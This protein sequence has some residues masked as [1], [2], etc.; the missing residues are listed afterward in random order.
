MSYRQIIQ[1]SVVVAI[2]LT[3]HGLAGRAAGEEFSA[4]GIEFFE[5]RVRPVFV[6]RCH[7]CHSAEAEKLKGEFRVD[8]REALLKG[9]ES[10]QPAILPGDAD[11]SRLIEAVRYLNVDLQMPPKN[12]LPEAQVADIVSWIKMGAPWTKETTARVAMV[13]KAEFDIEQRKQSHWSWKPIAIQPPPAVAQSDWPR[14]PGDRFILAKLEAV[15]LKP[16]PEAEKRTLARRLYF[17]LIGLPPTPGELDEFLQDASSEVYEKLV[18]RLLSSPHFGERWARHWLD[19]VRYSETL[20][21]EFDYPM[22]N[23]WRYRD[24]VIRAFNADVPYDQFAVEHIAGDLLESPRRHPTEKF[25][26]SMIGTGFYWLGQQSHSPVDVRANQ[27]DIIDNQI[28]VLTKTFMGL[29]VACARCHDHKFDAIPTKDFY[30]IYGMIGSSRFAQRAIDSPD[31]IEGCVT[32]LQE[33]KPKIRSALANAWQMKAAKVKDYLLASHAI[34][35]G[36]EPGGDGNATNTIAARFS[37]DAGLLAKWLAALRDQRPGDGA[38]PLRVWNQ[39]SGTNM[40]SSFTK[41]WRPIEVETSHSEKQAQRT[42]EVII[43]DFSSGVAPGWF[44]DGPAFGTATHGAG[45]LVIGDSKKMPLRILPKPGV[46]TAVISRRIQGAMRSP[47]FTITNRFAHI[48]AAGRDSR[49]NLVIDN[50]I[51]IQDPIYGGLRRVLDRDDLSWITIDLSMWRGH[52]AY[53]ELNDLAPAD[54]AAGGRPGGYGLN[55]W[56]AIDQVTFSDDRQAPLVK[57]VDFTTM[58]GDGEVRTIEMLAERYVHAVEAEIE[59]WGGTDMGKSQSSASVTHGETR[60]PTRHDSHSTTSFALLD[61]LVRNGLLDTTDDPKVT[62]LLDDYRAIENSIPE[63]TLVPAM[64]DGTGM[65]EVVFIRG[66]ART[67]GEIAPRRFLAAIGGPVQMPVGQGSGRLEFARRMTDSSNP[68]L[69]RVMV[70]RVWHHLFGRGIVPT[71]DDFGVLGQPPTHP[72][73]LDWL[74]NWF[75]TEGAWSTKRLVKMLVTSSTY[76]MSS[77]PNDALA[78]EKD[79]SNRLWHRME[80]RRL[81]G[82]VIRDAILSLSGRLDKTMFGSPVPIHLTQFMDGRGRPGTSGPL[83]GDGRRSIYVEVRRNFVSPMMRAFDTPVPMTT[84]GRRTMSNVPAQ[85]LILMNDPFVAGEMKRWAKRLLENHQKLPEQIVQEIYLATF[86]RAAN[87][88]EVGE[89]LA[90][91]RKQGEAYG[92]SGDEASRSERV[93]SDLCHVLLNVKEF[94]FVN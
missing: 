77:K 39:L 40:P 48:R 8:S 46:N 53:L 32:R 66:N 58:L 54:T 9:G 35:S 5:K 78:E 86:G 18:D 7:K 84:V 17:D 24:Y 57:P 67:P 72:E 45:E 4:E 20:G 69:A 33:L 76:R 90:F 49:L 59:K 94:V 70:N 26:E 13:K 80:V 62:T 64:V 56:A 74:A 3:V 63:P 41:A 37:V 91:V 93:W 68:F 30:S 27:S 38:H 44:V 51:M 75:R 79:P 92:A 82:E 19:L 12:K 21:H 88:V 73:L 28:D 87:A 83:D 52:R 16:S 14:Q 15:N 23:A 55:G 50:F 47:T 11:K 81:E 65:D 6:E 25:N 22:P 34:V 29:A 61:W 2:V 89:A 85:S 71:P 36:T 60:N 42:N 43:A 31:R 1:I 10:G